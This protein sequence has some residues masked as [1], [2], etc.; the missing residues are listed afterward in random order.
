M[1]KKELRSSEEPRRGGFA[2]GR[3]LNVTSAAASSRRP[4]EPLTW[5]NCYHIRINPAH[6]AE[7]NGKVRK[8]CR[9]WILHWEFGVPDCFFWRG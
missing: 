1:S 6:F 2:N 5:L 4:P 7:I 9:S 3:G 8:E